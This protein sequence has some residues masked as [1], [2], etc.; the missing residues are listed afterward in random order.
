MKSHFIF[1]VI[2]YQDIEI[3]R[4]YLQHLSFASLFLLTGPK[5]AVLNAK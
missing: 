5:E 4:N 2:I 1:K 3:E